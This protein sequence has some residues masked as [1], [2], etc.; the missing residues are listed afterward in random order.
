M[1][2]LQELLKGA[3]RMNL[4]ASKVAEIEKSLP[5]TDHVLGNDAVDRMKVCLR[6]G[7]SLSRMHGGGRPIAYLH[8]RL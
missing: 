2:G 5:G 1:H 7:P 8:E 3:Q 4:A 6:I